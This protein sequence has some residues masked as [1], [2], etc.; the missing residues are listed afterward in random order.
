MKTLIQ[1]VY[2]RYQ[3]QYPK[4]S[5]A[6]WGMQYVSKTVHYIV[7]GTTPV[8]LSNGGW[9]VSKKL[10]DQSEYG[11]QLWLFAESETEADRMESCYQPL[12][13]FAEKCR[14]SDPQDATGMALTLNPRY[15]A[16]LMHLGVPWKL[17]PFGRSNRIAIIE[18]GLKRACMA[19]V[20]ART[21]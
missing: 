8:W 11:R 20:M 15:I 18:L 2:E 3:Q 9:A 17:I 4:A 6:F 16:M 13:S 19:V 21:V 10:T 5:Q 1:G 12:A 7:D 14:M